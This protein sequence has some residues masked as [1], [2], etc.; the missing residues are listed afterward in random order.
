MDNIASIAG[1]VSSLSADILTAIIIAVLL[2]FAILSQGKKTYVAAMLAFYPAVFLYTYFPYHEV[3]TANSTGAPVFF[4]E[5]IVFFV[6]V[7]ISWFPIKY[8]I[9]KH[10]ESSSGKKG[11]HALL[12]SIS[13]TIELFIIVTIIIPITPVYELSSFTSQILTQQT[14][15][16]WGLVPI[17]SLFFLKK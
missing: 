16:W 3:F 2:F 14:I 17:T 15:F 6:F 11:F 7:V 4:S 9:R 10:I 12:L 1:Q 8:F 5:L 13:I